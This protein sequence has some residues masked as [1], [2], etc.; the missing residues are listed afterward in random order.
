MQG[1]GV[2]FHWLL[3]ALMTGMLVM[4]LVAAPRFV[5][6]TATTDGAEAAPLF[7]GAA[8]PCLLQEAEPNDGLRAA[9]DHARLCPAT[10]ILGTLP[11]GDSDD[12][13]WVEVDAPGTLAVKLGAIMPERDYDLYLYSEGQALLAESKQHSNLPEQLE[14]P[15]DAGR[16]LVRVHPFA[17]RSAD[18]YVLRWQLAPAPT[19]ET[20]EPEAPAATTNPSNNSD[21][22]ANQGR[23]NDPKPAKPDKPAK[24]DKPDDDERGNGKEDKEDKEDK[25]H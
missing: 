16:Y 19:A 14:L 1:S 4:L 5:A 22:N 25:D 13:Y 15:V 23:G 11:D 24:R 10:T 12:L 8:Q 7:A 17:G 18:P 9:T 6:P 20:E 3:G 2:P 21:P